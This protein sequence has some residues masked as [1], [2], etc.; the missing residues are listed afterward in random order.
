MTIRH[1]PAEATSGPPPAG[2]VVA[3]IAVLET[4]GEVDANARVVETDE[5]AAVVV[6]LVGAGVLVVVVDPEPRSPPPPLEQAAA[7]S[8]AE[9][10]TRT[11][12]RGAGIMAGR[13]GP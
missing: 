2:C 11:T 9:E 1:P 5:A 12:H 4:P 3:G 6:V 13:L 8:E 7:R 10:S